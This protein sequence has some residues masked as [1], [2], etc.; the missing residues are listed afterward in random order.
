MHTDLGKLVSFLGFFPSSLFKMSYMVS[1]SCMRFTSLLPELHSDKCM[2]GKISSDTAG[3]AK[4]SFTG[5]TP[6][7]DRVKV[8][9]GQLNTASID[10]VSIS[11]PNNSNGSG[12][13]TSQSTSS[14]STQ[15]KNGNAN[16][17]GSSGG[18]KSSSI[19]LNPTGGT[20]GT[21][22]KTSA[23]TSAPNSSNG[24]GASTSKPN[25]SSGTQTKNGNANGSGVTNGTA[26]ST[27]KGGKLRRN[28]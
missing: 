12:T 19:A 3:N 4:C 27:P 6:D 13:S 21:T 26:T 28:K 25:D 10:G 24:P 22:A 23:P 14:N 7:D 8:N 20:A 9:C 1:F 16:N 11:A 2:C 17:S 18:N 15:T 5:D